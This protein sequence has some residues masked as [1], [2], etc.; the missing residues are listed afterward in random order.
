MG[1]PDRILQL[2]FLQLTGF[3]R[4]YF[5]PLIPLEGVCKRFL[6]LVRTDDLKLITRTNAPRVNLFRS[7]RSY[8]KRTENI[9]LEVLVNY[10]EGTKGSLE[11][12]ATS[13]LA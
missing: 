10:A 7:I 1:M 9:I 13:S 4:G 6:G 2:I 11:F 12:C 8:Q 3:R 5:S